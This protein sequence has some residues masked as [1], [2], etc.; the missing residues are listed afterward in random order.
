[1]KDVGIAEFKAHLSRY[2]REAKLGGA[3]TITDRGTPVARLGPAGDR[4]GMRERPASGR[5]RDLKLP[6]PSDIDFD[7]VEWL[8]E[9]RR[10]DR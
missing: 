2:L 4:N 8:L 6:P 3:V 9:T 10:N 7:I 5:L 1:M